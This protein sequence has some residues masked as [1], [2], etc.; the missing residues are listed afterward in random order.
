MAQLMGVD[1]CRG[2]WVAVLLDTEQTAIVTR[3]FR[4]ARGFVRLDP[5][6]A[7]I[8]VD[9]P[10]GLPARGARS[11][12]VLVRRHLGRPRG[13]SVF[14]APLRAM[15]DASS[16]EEADALGRATDG[17]GLGCQAWNLVP[18]IREL[19]A[20]VGRAEQDRV[21]EAHPEASFSLW[22]GAPLAHGK[23]TKAGQRERR[24]L[25]ASRYGNDVFLRLRAEHAR[26]HV[27]DDDLLD[28]FALLWTAER[29]HAG[30]AVRWPEDPPR[31]AR[32]L[33]MEI[34]A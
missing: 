10:L 2:G 13:S 32:G 33:R 16:R 8:A 14:P 9:M 18:K 15:L 24:A 26:Q 25:V 11:C 7:L 21:R 29:L 12:D 6:P 28:A 1:G 20:A 31:D 5:P 22:A 3:R 34:W 19:D 4:S 30:T 27:A 23:R 17:R